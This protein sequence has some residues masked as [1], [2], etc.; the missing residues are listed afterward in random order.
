MG[1]HL[2]LIGK[3]VLV[4]FPFDD[5]SSSKV[6]PAVCLTNFIGVHH[7]VILA[8]ITSQRPEDLLESDLILDSNHS[9]FKLTGLRV[10]STL[11]LHRLMTVSSNLIQRE[12]GDL[13]PRVRTIMVDK[14]KK[15]FDLT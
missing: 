6:R 12:L 9:D 13:S 8:F 5:L 1:S 7:H 3:V 11:R 15:I 4:P 14:L 10:T 2:M